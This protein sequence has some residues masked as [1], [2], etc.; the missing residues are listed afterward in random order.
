[1]PQVVNH[2]LLPKWFERQ[3]QNDGGDASDLGTL[4]VALAKHGVNSRGWRLYLDYGDSLFERL[5]RPWV[6]VDW[7]FSSGQNAAEFLRLLQACEMD[8]LPPPEMVE[9]LPKWDI[10]RQRIRMLPTGLFRLIWKA[11]I[12]ASYAGQTPKEFLESHAVPVVRW[13]F[14]AGLHEDPDPNLL[15]A[16]WPALERRFNE[17]SATQELIQEAVS[18]VSAEWPV[19][20]KRVESSGYRFIALGSSTALELEGMEMAHCI[21]G[22]GARCQ[23]GMLRAWSIQEMKTSKRV[24][25]LTVLETA[26]GQWD[27]DELKA[28]CNSPVPSRIEELAYQVVWALEESWRRSPSV[29]H[30]MDET[31]N[32][33][34]TYVQRTIRT[35]EIPPF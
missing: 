18:P 19:F 25:T 10:P 32:R 31:R 1:M 11:C 34:T 23:S 24:A 21:G 28:W 4:K 6:S 17:W 5:G 20:L 35:Y 7:E 8:V 9:S 12:S 30:E 2:V 29:R 27:V 15:K 26:P 3:I 33:C 22:Y 13:F 14:S 16:G